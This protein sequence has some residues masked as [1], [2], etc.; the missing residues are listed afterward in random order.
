MWGCW[1]LGGWGWIGIGRYGSKSEVELPMRIKLRD[2][3][4]VT[5]PLEPSNVVEFKVVE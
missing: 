1:K 5:F 4:A 2:P 3:G